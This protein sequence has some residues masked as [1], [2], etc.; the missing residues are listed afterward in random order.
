MIFCYAN[1]RNFSNF[2][3]TT[4]WKKFIPTKCIVLLLI[5]KKFLQHDLI[6]LTQINYYFLKLIQAFLTF[7]SKYNDQLG[8]EIKK[9]I[10]LIS[11]SW[12]NVN[13]YG[14][15]G[16]LLFFTLFKIYKGTFY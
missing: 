3:V 8:Y 5:T 11:D 6:N 10:D 13:D 14:P 2:K 12:Y 7:Q 15:S 16:T 9:K 1:L 4:F